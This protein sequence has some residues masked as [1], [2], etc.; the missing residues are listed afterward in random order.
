MNIPHTFASRNHSR[1]VHSAWNRFAMANCPIVE[2]SPSK[3]VGKDV[4]ELQQRASTTT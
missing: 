2:I 3:W 1:I 4:V